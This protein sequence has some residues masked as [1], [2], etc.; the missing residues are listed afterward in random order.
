[1]LGLIAAIVVLFWLAI[2]VIRALNVYIRKTRL[3]IDMNR[4]PEGDDIG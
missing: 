1:M 2:T 4:P 3:E